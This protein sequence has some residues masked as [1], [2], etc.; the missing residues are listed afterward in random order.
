MAKEI[1]RKFLVKTG[2]IKLPGNGDHIHQG[3]LSS[4]PERSVRVRLKNDRAYLTIKGGTV[5]MERTEFEYE[6][7]VNDATTMLNELCE[8]P[9]IEKHRF[10]LNY[11][12]FTWEVDVFHG[13]NEGLVLA[14]I[15][16]ISSG[17]EFPLPPWIDREVTNDMRYYNVNLVAHPYNSW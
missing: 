10:V 6:I 8:K 2:Q 7:P 12:G 11:K 13:E 14:E 15:E 16:L 9:T 5:D 4:V 3:Y 1:E 17:Q